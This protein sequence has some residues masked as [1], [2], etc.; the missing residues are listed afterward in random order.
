MCLDPRGPF[1]RGPSPLGKGFFYL[2][3][4]AILPLRAGA[5]RRLFLPA[6]FP[7][8]HRGRT[9]LPSYCP[10]FICGKGLEPSG[11]L[12]RCGSTFLPIEARL[13]LKG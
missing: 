10:W 4:S 12:E 6:P 1:L 2:M 11:L 13:H 5:V 7:N 9:Q 8:A 3:S